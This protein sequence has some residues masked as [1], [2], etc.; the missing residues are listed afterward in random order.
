MQDL[1]MRWYCTDYTYPGGGLG[2]SN[3]ATAFLFFVAEYVYLIDYELYVLSLGS[4]ALKCS[5]IN[6]ILEK[7]IYLTFLC[8]YINAMRLNDLLKHFNIPS[9]KREIMYTPWKC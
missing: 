8:F 7:Y 9:N 4:E 6:K 1:W 5:E 2:I 3:T